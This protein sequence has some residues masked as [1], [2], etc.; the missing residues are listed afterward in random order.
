MLNTKRT[1]HSLLLEQNISAEDDDFDTIRNQIG[2]I[3]NS[4]NEN[5]RNKKNLKN[6]SKRM[7]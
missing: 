2:Q 1:S 4:N 3:T 5:K 6:K 7:M